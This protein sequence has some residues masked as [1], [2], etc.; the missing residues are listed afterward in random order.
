MII[1]IRI[2]IYSLINDTKDHIIEFNDN[3]I[4]NRD[5]YIF[6]KNSDQ[7]RISLYNSNDNRLRDNI[8]IR[9][10]RIRFNKIRVNK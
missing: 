3:K 9:L 2:I 7:T 1:I 8:N 10:E 6:V 5:N 4:E